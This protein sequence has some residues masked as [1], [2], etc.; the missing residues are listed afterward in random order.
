[1]LLRRFSLI[2]IT[3][4]LSLGLSGS[5]M[6]DTK[7]PRKWKTIT[8]KVKPGDTLTSI[9]QK[10]HTSPEKLMKWNRG[11]EPTN[12]QIGQP[13]KI[14]IINPEWKE[15]KASG[16]K[17][18]N[19]SKAHAKKSSRKKKSSSKKVASKKK[20]VDTAKAEK[21][22]KDNEKAKLARSEKP[23]EKK[24][25]AE[26][27]AP[28]KKID[29]GDSAD[30]SA[31]PPKLIASNDSHDH[32]HDHDHADTEGDITDAVDTSED[33]A[34]NTDEQ[35]DIEPGF[36]DTPDFVPTPTVAARPRGPLPKSFNYKGEKLPVVTGPDMIDSDLKR[37]VYFVGDDENIGSIAL[38]FR[39]DPED[40]LYWNDLDRIKL[41]P[42]EVLVFKF[43]AKPR[44]PKKPLPT[45]HRVKRGDTYERIAKKYGVSVKQLKRWNPRVNPR[46]LQIGQTIRMYIPG[47]DGRSVSY[48]T[49]NRG[50]LYNGVALETTEGL[51]VRTVSNAY[52]TER[53]IRLLKGAAFD[54][55]ARWPDAPNMVVGDIS[56]RRGGRIKKHK[57]HQSGRDAD[58]SFFY[59]GNVQTRD[60]VDMEHETF[61]AVKNWHVFKTLIDTGEV[62]YIFIDYPLQKVLYEYARA[63][64]YTEEELE[65]LIQYPRPKSMGV[66]IIRHVRGHD[67]HWHIRFKCGPEDRHCR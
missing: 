16:G 65:P 63:I 64:G 18:R 53:V 17:K 38:K 52:G 45:V 14:A 32:D 28:P 66:G 22:N 15:W 54:L 11:L 26:N 61:D 5:A 49:A 46:R 50:K 7:E 4:L 51:K 20:K 9:A 33:V 57:S 21:S 48:G 12:L 44:V 41:H 27:N 13:L 23:E 36:D 29:D 59:R 67:D 2:L 39:L 34:S 8:Y 58:V 24:A 30:S 3:A 6:A 10:Y 55:Q 19:K 1:M 62:E 47:R 60:F 42:E 43:D 56:Y 37:A 40:L 35:D 31:K 25:V